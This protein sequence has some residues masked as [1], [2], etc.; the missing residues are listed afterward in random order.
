MQDAGVQGRGQV[1]VVDRAGR[2]VLQHLSVLL[3]L[4]G[5]EPIDGQVAV[6][7]SDE[8]DEAAVVLD[9]DVGGLDARLQ[10]QDVL[11]LARLGLEEALQSG[12][13]EGQL[14]ELFL[15][16]ASLVFTSTLLFNNDFTAL[17][18]INHALDIQH[19]SLDPQGSLSE[20]ALVAGKGVLDLLGEFL[21]VAGDDALVWIVI[22]EKFDGRVLVVHEL[23]VD[24]AIVLKRFSVLLGSIAQHHAV[25]LHAD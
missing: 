23:L 8:V 21:W 22:R 24:G 6:V 9:V 10:V 15:V 2:H 4:L 16:V 3:H 14:F 13:A 7:D 18:R 20:W 19:L 1:G 11:L 25:F 12:L 17:E 5:L